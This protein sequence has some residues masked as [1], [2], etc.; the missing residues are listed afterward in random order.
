MRV[1][2]R[3]A[4]CSPARISPRWHLGYLMCVWDC[5]S[6]FAIRIAI[7]LI[8]KAKIARSPVRRHLR[9][10]PRLQALDDVNHL[11]GSSAIDQVNG[12]LAFE[13]GMRGMQPD[14]RFIGREKAA[15][16]IDHISQFGDDRLCSEVLGTPCRST[17][18]KRS[19]PKRRGYW[20]CLSLAARLR[21]G[22]AREFE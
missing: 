13:H 8:E 7:E 9:V 3:A 4:L 6:S 12:T 19:P 16:A 5:D 21:R 11:F 20:L 18:A 15:H 14:T 17:I 1:K 22:A 10:G 2:K